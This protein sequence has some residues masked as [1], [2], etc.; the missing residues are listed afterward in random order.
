MKKIQ[1]ISYY[2]YLNKWLQFDRYKNRIKCD[3]KKTK[4][5]NT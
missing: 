3:I 1:A 2:L 5:I 4:I